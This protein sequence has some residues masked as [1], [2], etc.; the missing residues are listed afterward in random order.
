MS[1]SVREIPHP[2]SPRAGRAP[3]A[4]GAGDFYSTA[5]PPCEA[6]APKYEAASLAYGADV[7]FVK[8]FRQGS[9]A[10]S[11]TLGVKSSPTVL[12]FQ[13][14]K[15]VGARL[16]GAIKR[17]E[18][19]A[20]LDALLSPARARAI[21]ARER[22]FTTECDV[23]ILG[24]G[25]AGITA[26]IYAAQAK[27]RTIMVDIGLGGGNLAIT[28]Q[29]SNFP[30]FPKPQPGYMLA[31]MMLEHAKAAG[32][33]PRFAAE[34]T[35]ADLSEHVVEL[36]GVETVRA[37]KIIVATGSSPRPLGVPGEQEYKGKGISYCATCDAKYYEGKHVVVVGGGN[38]AVEESLFIAKFASRITMV[39]QLEALTANR[40]AQ[41]RVFAERKIEMLLRHEPRAFLADG[42]KTV[43]AV[44][45]EDL[46][47]GTQRQLPVDGA[48]VFAGMQPNL[49]GLGDVFELDA[50]GYVKTDGEMHTNVPGVFAAGDVVSKRFRQMTTAVSDGTIASMALSKE[51]A[52]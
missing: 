4:R 21:H 37:K 27:L 50:W 28:H 7:K 32:V 34:I 13:R 29:V 3:A 15:E 6:L 17:S 12:F 23:L 14:G 10:L 26:G 2:A 20:Q 41:E 52:A 45:V 25:P 19:V 8:I 40:E 39:H 42:G 35:R 9:R 46:T 49:E 18:L 1:A 36:G 5:C 48:F 30:G 38:S 51:L 31:H 44:V 11:D 22:R 24:A 43:D 47:T 16:G 33:E